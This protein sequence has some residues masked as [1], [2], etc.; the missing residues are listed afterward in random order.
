MRKLLHLV[1]RL[2]EEGFIAHKLL[3]TLNEPDAMIAIWSKHPLNSMKRKNVFLDEMTL[4]GYDARST[5]DF[6]RIDVV[7]DDN[8]AHVYFFSSASLEQ[9][10]GM[11][12]HY[13][14]VFDAGKFDP[15]DVDF[16]HTKARLGERPIY[17][18]KYV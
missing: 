14:H 3:P 12:F 17:T 2:E 1:S 15:I 5:D 16:L 11:N 8:T 10:M 6:S 13:V 4:A 7:I 9:T 18:A